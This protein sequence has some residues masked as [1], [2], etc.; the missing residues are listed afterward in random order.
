[1]KDSLSAE[2]PGKPKNTGMGSLSLKTQL[3]KDLPAMQETLVQFLGQEDPLVK[4]QA[5]HSSIL[6]LPWW[7]SWQTI[8]LQCGRPGFNPWVGKIPW[9]RDRLP[10]PVFWPGEFH[11]LYSQW[12]SLRV[13]HDRTT[14]TF[15]HIKETVGF[16]ASKHLLGGCHLLGKLLKARNTKLRA[17]QPLPSGPRKG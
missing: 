4:G 5:T 2:S 6:G 3:V 13:R 12:G 16:S 8:H 11:G 7:L 9:G 1:M 15:F 14:F 17:G 10:N